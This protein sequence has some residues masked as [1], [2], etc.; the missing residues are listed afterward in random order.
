MSNQ[1]SQEDHDLALQELQDK[2]S[3]KLASIE[4]MREAEIVKRVAAA[5]AL[6][7]TRASSPLHGK[8]LFRPMY[9]SPMKNQQQKSSSA[10]TPSLAASSSGISSPQ[11]DLDEALR[12]RAIQQQPQE[13]AWSKRSLTKA[14]LASVTLLLKDF[15]IHK[16][17]QFV[18]SLH[19]CCGVEFL[20]L[21]EGHGC[22]NS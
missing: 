10:P 6:S 5:L 1:I 15:D 2:Y 3:A 22:E 8:S 20:T 21:L 18:K 19:D 12:A 13:V 7:T 14:T 4:H 11:T 16:R 17:K 9:T